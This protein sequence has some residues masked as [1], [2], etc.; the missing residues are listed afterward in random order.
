MT[1]S[2]IKIERFCHCGERLEVT[3]ADEDEARAKLEAW[4]RLHVGREDDGTVH[5]PMKR[6]DYWKMIRRLNAELKAEAERLLKQQAAM[7]QVKRYVL[8]K[9]AR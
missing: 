4:L 9:G 5:A 2:A 7:P 1:N 3:A 6:R 8:R